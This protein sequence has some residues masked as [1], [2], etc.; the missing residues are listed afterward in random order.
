[1]KLKILLLLLL[2]PSVS[3]LVVDDAMMVNDN[4]KSIVDSAGINILL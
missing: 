4:L 1:M 3:A 2:M